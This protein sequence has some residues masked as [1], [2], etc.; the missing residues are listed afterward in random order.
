MPLVELTLPAEIDEAWRH[1]REPAL[2]RRWFGW[3]YD[4]LDQEIEVIFLQEAMVGDYELG[5][6]DPLQGGDRI[7]LADAGPQT[8]LRIHREA[9]G[10]DALAEGWTS[11]AHQLRFALSHD[12]ER[13]TLRL[14]GG[15]PRADLPGE[16]YFATEHQA[17][18]VADGALVLV[19]AD[20]DGTAALTVSSFGGEPDEARWRA[21]WGA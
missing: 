12:G 11:F 18:T 19:A 13:R 14:T 17:A 15:R 4:G 9:E 16:P 10:F 8:I 2:I 6:G 21:W 7:V 5:W 3:E 20:A 1:L